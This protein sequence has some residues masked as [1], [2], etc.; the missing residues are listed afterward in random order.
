LVL[1][2]A[3][4]KCFVVAEVPVFCDVQ[5]LVAGIVSYLVTL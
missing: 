3:E 1:L 5:P 4:S 2:Q